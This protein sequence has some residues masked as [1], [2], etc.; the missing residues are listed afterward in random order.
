MWVVVDTQTLFIEAVLNCIVF[1]DRY[2]LAYK[3][4]AALCDHPD[5]TMVHTH[6]Q[7]LRLIDNDGSIA[8]QLVIHKS[9]TIL[10]V[11]VGIPICGSSR[12]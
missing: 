10:F 12:D 3:Q 8:N 1:I 11:E 5:E 9:A 2:A 6:M 4:R 7:G